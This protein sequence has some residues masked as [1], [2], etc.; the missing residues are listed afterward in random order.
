VLCCLASGRFR[1]D[2]RTCER[3]RS[4]RAAPPPPG[5]ATR[6]S[7]M[8]RRRHGA[9]A[10]AVVNPSAGRCGHRVP[11]GPCAQH[12]RSVQYMPCA[13]VRVAQGHK[14]GPAA[15]TAV[16]G[17][18]GVVV[19][20]VR[21]ERVAVTAETLLTNTARMSPE[22]RDATLWYIAMASP[23][24]A[25]WVRWN[26]RFPA[27]FVIGVLAQFGALLALA[28]RLPVVAYVLFSSGSCCSR[29]R[30][31]GSGGFPRRRSTSPS[32]P[33]SPLRTDDRCPTRSPSRT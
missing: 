4:G 6:R 27:L 1:C 24:L 26:A 21:H 16:I 19:L 5:D 31:C 32:A 2:S 17:R 14:A 33:A 7:P 18:V 13:G 8:W 3:F 20:L 11:T 22:Q 9:E 29:R 15:G 30:A 12:G 25:Y 10:G 28:F 23:V